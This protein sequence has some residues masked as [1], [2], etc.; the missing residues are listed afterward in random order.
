MS[1]LFFKG[2]ARV[3]LPLLW[4]LKFSQFVSFELRFDIRVL[5]TNLE[6]TVIIIGE[7]SEDRSNEIWYTKYEKPIEVRV[8][9]DSS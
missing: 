4:V 8:T 6:L 9:Y 2:S 3:R 1:M 7:W 5:G